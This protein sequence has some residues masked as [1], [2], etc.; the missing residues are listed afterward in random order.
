[1]IDDQQNILK[2]VNRFPELSVAFLIG[3]VLNSVF[4]MEMFGSLLGCKHN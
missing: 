3:S 2:R 1:M 4:V